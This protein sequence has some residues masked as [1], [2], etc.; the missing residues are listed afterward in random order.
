[1]NIVY[2]RQFKLA[3]K[4]RIQPDKRLRTLFEESL[5]FFM[6]DPNEP[7]LRVHK[8]HGILAEHY[9][10][11]VD[12]DCRVI[13]KKFANDTFLFVDIGSHDQVY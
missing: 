12:L 6:A 11:S 10:F 1:M 7:G 13:F 5:S 8:L 2:S 4:S 9:A 3:F